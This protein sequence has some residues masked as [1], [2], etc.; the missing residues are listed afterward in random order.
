MSTETQNKDDDKIVVNEGQDG[1]AVIEL[2][3][4]IQ[5]DQQDEDDDHDFQFDW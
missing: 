3:D 2:P 1:S 5:G 4:H